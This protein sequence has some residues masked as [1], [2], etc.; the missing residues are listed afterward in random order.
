MAQRTKC[1]ECG[2]HRERMVYFPG[3]KWLCG[4]C[5]DE[6]ERIVHPVAGMKFVGLPSTTHLRQGVTGFKPTGRSWTR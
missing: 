3:G 5:S 1:E 2:E 6:R 4:P